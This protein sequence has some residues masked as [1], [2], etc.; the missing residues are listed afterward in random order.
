[1][2]T[3][4]PLILLLALYAFILSFARVRYQCR[5]FA[6]TEECETSLYSISL[7][8]YAHHRYPIGKAQV[9]CVVRKGE[10]LEAS[11]GY[12]ETFKDLPAI[13][14]AA[15]GIEFFEEQTFPT[16]YTEVCKWQ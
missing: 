13:G 3:F 11:H 9:H 5:P 4:F 16:Q 1:M 14:N 8:S 2:K 10:L 7:Y 15:I 12:V 6:P